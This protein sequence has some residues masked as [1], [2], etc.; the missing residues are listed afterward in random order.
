MTVKTALRLEVSACPALKVYAGEENLNRPDPLGHPTEIPDIAATSSSGGEMLLT[1]GAGIGSTAE[2]QSP[3]PPADRRRAG[4]GADHRT[5]RTRSPPCQTRWSTRRTR[6]RLPLVGL[7]SLNC[8]SSRS[9]GWVHESIYID[10]RVLDPLDAYR[11]LN[12]T[13]MQLL[14]AMRPGAVHRR[15]GRRSRPP[16]RARNATCQVV[17]YSG[18]SMPSDAVLAEWGAPLPHRPTTQQPATA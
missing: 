1:A 16:R 8:R 12:A 11:R 6:A 7:D 15:A 3:L 18:A 13:F 5:E 4:R 17:A 9:V 2:Q 10:R 14:L